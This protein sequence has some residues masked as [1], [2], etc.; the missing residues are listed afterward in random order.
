MTLL[1]LMRPISGNVTLPAPVHILL[2]I[3]TYHMSLVNLRKLGAGLPQKRQVINILRK[4][5][6]FYEI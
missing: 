1:P 6:V 5:P 2:R 3:P 4:S